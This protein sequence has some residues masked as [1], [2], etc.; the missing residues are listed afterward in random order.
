MFEFSNDIFNDF[1]EFDSNGVI[2]RFVII[3][4]SIWH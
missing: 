2:P 4:V 1:K 3:L